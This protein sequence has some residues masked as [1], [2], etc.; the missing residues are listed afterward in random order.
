MY[1][2]GDATNVTIVNHRISKKVSCKQ[3]ASVTC[4]YTYCSL[5]VIRTSF[6]LKTYYQHIKCKLILNNSHL[7]FPE[8]DRDAAQLVL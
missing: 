3:R 7:T 4:A 1:S 6:E 8:V 5:P 2:Q